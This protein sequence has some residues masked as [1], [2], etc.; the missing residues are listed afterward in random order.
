MGN[1]ITLAEEIMLLSLDDESGAVRQRQSVA[2]ALAGAILLELVLAERVSIS[3]KHMEL[4]STEPTGEPLLDGR[5]RLIETWMRGLGRRRLADWLTKD[6]MKA[7]GPVLERLGE[8]GLVAE[9]V[10][11]VLGV[12]PR[13]RYPEV[14]GTVERALRQ[15][16]DA[17]VLGDAPPDDRTAGL[18]ALL[19]GAKLHRLAFPGHSP[20]AVKPRMAQ[21]AAGQWA[22]DGVQAAIRDMQAAMLVVMAATAAAVS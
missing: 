8:R 3:G 16:L 22:A 17:A 12:F 18:I 21:I 9:Q 1:T 20:A 4:R 2:P 5:I 14:D 15:R 6:H 13:R 19:H 10:D 11:K 7:T